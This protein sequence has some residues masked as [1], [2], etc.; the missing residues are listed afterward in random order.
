MHTDT[1]KY[2]Q[3]THAYIHADKQT[4]RL[5]N[6][7]SHIHTYTYTYT[8]ITLHYIRTGRQAGRQTGCH[9]NVHSYIQN[10]NAPYIHACIHTYTTLQYTALHYIT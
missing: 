9:V 10:T 5:P 1:H 4:D 6:M 3:K 8:Y 2:M 7:R